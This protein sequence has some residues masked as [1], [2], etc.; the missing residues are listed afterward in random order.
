V[1]VRPLTP[2][3]DEADGLVIPARLAGHPALDFCNTFAGWGDPHGGDYL[4]T[5]DHLA[6]WTAAAGLIDEASAPR[7]RRRA[8]GD[9][10][11][12]ASE[13]RRAVSLRAALYRVCTEGTRRTRAWDTVAAEAEAAGAAAELV[14]TER[15]AEWRLPDRLGLALPVAAVAR[16]AADLLTS[17]D[18]TAVGRCPGEECGWLFLDPTGRRRW[19]TMAVCGNRAKVRR[20]AQRARARRG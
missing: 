18:L 9:P 11:A 12:A 6:V 14:R 19:C 10:A 15:G 16:S 17:G 8:A 7:L 1:I 13:L 20:F 5:F 4:K 3:A 2:Y